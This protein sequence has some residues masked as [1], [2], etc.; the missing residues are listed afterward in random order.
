MNISDAKKYLKQIRSEQIEIRALLEQREVTRLSLYPKAITYDGS[1]VQASS[2]DILSERMAKICALDDAIVLHVKQ[3]DERKAQAMQITAKIED[4]VCRTLIELYYLSIRSDGRL[5]RWADV[6][7]MMG[8]DEK[9]VIKRIHPRALR[10]F[11]K[12]NIR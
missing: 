7:D 8:Y 5:M 3:L 1:K 12:K 11:S 10:E 9:H 4:P 6:A 2:R